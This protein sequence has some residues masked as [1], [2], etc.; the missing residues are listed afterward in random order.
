LAQ[1][2]KIA[3]NSLLGATA[4]TAW[5]RLIILMIQDNGRAE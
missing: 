1:W 4:E 5:N 3:T 2:V